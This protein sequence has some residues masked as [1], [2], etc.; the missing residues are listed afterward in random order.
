MGLFVGRGWS[1]GIGEE[2]EKEGFCF[3]VRLWVAGVFLSSV[4]TQ[5]HIRDTLNIP[6]SIARAF[7]R[8]IFGRS[9]VRS[10]L[11]TGNL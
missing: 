8:S 6:D 2:T 9:S 11:V 1:I 5:V 4:D 3:V 10:L 7:P